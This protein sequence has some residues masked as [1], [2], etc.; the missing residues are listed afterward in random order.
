MHEMSSAAPLVE[1][2]GL[3][4]T[5]SGRGGDVLAVDDVDLTIATGE[6]VGVVGESGSGKSTLARLIARLIDPTDGSMTYAGSDFLALKGRELREQRR[7]IQMVFQNP[8]G[9]LLPNLT[10][11][12]NVAEPLR[13]HRSGD[14]ASRRA[15]AL[16][17]L[18]LVGVNTKNADMYP[19]RFSG[20]QQQRVAIA[21]ALA[22][23]PTLLICDEPTSALDASIQAQILSLLIRLKSELGFA[24]LFISHNLAV[25]DRLADRVA[26]MNSGR[27]VESALTQQIFN[28]PQHPYTRTLL[29]A[30]LPVRGPVPLSVPPGLDTRP[31]GSRLI[32]VTPQHF[33]RVPDDDGRLV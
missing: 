2:R 15:R 7:E 22:L 24:M 26:V 21:R 19:R 27:I 25:V 5:F 33:V 14:R 3:T 9:S 17:L 6:T 29:S 10:I 18:D 16:E 32:E 1:A 4:K 12:D 11:A 23:E 20:G 13:L 31:L 30:V 8:F 28:D